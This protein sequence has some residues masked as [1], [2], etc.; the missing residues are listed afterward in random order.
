MLSPLLLECSFLIPV[1]RDANLSDGQLHDPGMWDWFTNE[2]HER[3]GA[4]T[5]APGLYVGSYEDPDTH[6]RV[7][8]ESFKYIVAVEEPRMGELRQL[9]SAACV[10]FQQKCIYLSVAGRVEFVEAPTS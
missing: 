7:T 4:Q 3:F 9:L 5:A 10:L 8:D 1:R 6:E 2:L